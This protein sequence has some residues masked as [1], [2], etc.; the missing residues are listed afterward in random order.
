MRQQRLRICSVVELGVSYGFPAMLQLLRIVEG[1]LERGDVVR[2]RVANGGLE[3]VEHRLRVTGLL[4]DGSQA[5]GMVGHRRGISGANVGAGLLLLRIRQGLRRVEPDVASGGVLQSVDGRLVGVNEVAEFLEGVVRLTSPIEEVVFDSILGGLDVTGNLRGRE[6]RGKRSLRVVDVS[7]AGDLALDCLDLSLDRGDLAL[8]GGYVR[9]GGRDVRG[10]GGRLALHV[11]QA[12]GVVVHRGLGRV[13]GCEDLVDRGNSGR[14]IRR[15]KTRKRS[16]GG[17]RS[18]D[19][20][21]NARRKC[22][23]LS[24][25]VGRVSHVS[26]LTVENTVEN[27]RRVRIKR[28]LLDDKG[29]DLR[30]GC[31]AVDLEEILLRVGIHER[32]VERRTLVTGVALRSDA[33]GDAWSPIP[34]EVRLLEIEDAVFPVEVGRACDEG[35]IDGAISGGAHVHGLEA[36]ASVAFLALLT[37]F[38]LRTGVTL[39]AGVTLWAGVAL[40]ALNTLVA[41]RTDG[42]LRATLALNALVATRPHRTL[43]P[44]RALQT[45]GA[46]RAG[47]AHRTNFA[48]LASRALLALLALQAGFALRAS[49]AAE[50]LP[51][52][53]VP[54][55]GGLLEVERESVVIKKRERRLG[56]VVVIASRQRTGRVRLE[57]LALRALFALRTLDALRTDGATLADGALLASRTYRTLRALR[58]DRTLDARDAD[59]PDP[60]KHVVCEDLIHMSAIVT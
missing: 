30:T 39:R 50:A 41:T 60:A 49:L 2:R 56:V 32:L 11:G 24:G 26:S 12:R 53:P 55:G 45:D 16:D 51:G 35:V 25:L 1:G 3:G 38:T 48:L 13:E 17:L 6:R 42:T 19:F 46:L 21:T 8:Q 47:R 14:L 28:G 44:L 4:L 18:L 33:E 59:N 57:A 43:S 20:V 27:C 52:R 36:H 58:T 5:C 9:L 23:N 7:R 22:S 29:A 40:Q 15:G 10:V 31:L 37:T 34:L 54:R